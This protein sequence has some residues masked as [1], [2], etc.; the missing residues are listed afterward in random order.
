[1]GEEG[2]LLAELSWQDGLQQLSALVT[3]CP[4]TLHLHGKLAYDTLVYRKRH[5]EG[6]FHFL[7]QMTQ[8]VMRLEL[9][10]N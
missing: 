6:S 4:P 9:C 2:G 1:V 5:R 3:P 8:A 10:S 7:I